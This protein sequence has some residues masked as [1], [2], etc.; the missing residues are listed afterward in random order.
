MSGLYLLGVI[1]L[2]LLVTIFLWR[3]SRRWRVSERR[4]LRG[5]LALIV[6]LL[7]LG[8]SFWYVGGRN[9]YYDWQVEKLCAVDGGIKVYETVTLTSGEYDQHVKRNWAFPKKTGEESS[10]S[11]YSEDDIYYLRKAEPTL[12]RREYRII[13]RK[14]RKVLGK[15]TRYGR[16]GGDFPGPWHSS[17]FTCPNPT[18]GPYLEPSIFIK[19]N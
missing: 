14:D 11:Y 5:K 3:I 9:V 7:W 6:A 12:T 1:A 16:G 19:E 2:W 13:R 4:K 8:V 17:S 18:E 10:G 15:S